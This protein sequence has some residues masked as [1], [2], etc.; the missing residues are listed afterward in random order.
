MANRTQWIGGGLNGANTTAFFAA[1]NAADFTGLANLS[2]VMS[3]IPAFDNTALGDQF[4]DIS[5]VGTI[6][7][8]TIGASAGMSFFLAALQ[9]DNATYGDGRLVAGTQTAYSPI[10]NPMGGFA[11]QQGT[12]IVNIVGS[13]H[14]QNLPPRKFALVCQNFSGFALATGNCWIST[15]RQNT[16]A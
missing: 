8:S 15:Y 3:S 13:V 12:T 4:M 10:Q 1:F 7:S 11:I 14:V 9:G 16:N 2:S 6:A 5:F